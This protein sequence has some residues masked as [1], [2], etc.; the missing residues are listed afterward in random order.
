MLH[1]RDKLEYIEYSL[2]HIYGDSVGGCLY[3]TIK[4]AFYE[5]FYD[6]CASCKPPTNNDSQFGH[7]FIATEGASG[8]SVKSGS[9]VKARFKKHKLELG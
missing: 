6:Y 4:A 8:D 1:P 3:C 5:L 9:L 2:N 7:S